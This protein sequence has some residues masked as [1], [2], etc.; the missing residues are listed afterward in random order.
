MAH[1]SFLCRNFFF[2]K[3][4]RSSAYCIKERVKYMYKVWTNSGPLAVNPTKH[5]TQLQSCSTRGPGRR[6]MKQ[7]HI[8]SNQPGHRHRRHG[9]LLKNPAPS[10][11]PDMP[12][13]INRERDI[14]L[15]P[16]VLSSLPE[17]LPLGRKSLR[18]RRH[19]ERPW[20]VSPEQRPH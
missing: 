8:S 15:V 1:S 16:I 6:K 17:L 13:N 10:L 7:V 4:S 19:E 9:Y 2:T 11:F 20:T 18:A 12:N 5:K 14:A 3:T